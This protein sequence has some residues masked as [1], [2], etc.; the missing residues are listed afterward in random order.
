RPGTME[1][2]VAPIFQTTLGDELYDRVELV[3][4]PEFLREGTAIQDYFN[5][6]KIVVGTY[7][8]QPSE[9]MEQL[10]KGIDA[11]VFHVKYR[12][13]E[14]TKFVD[15][16]WHAAKVAFANEIGRICHQMDI[17][18]QQVHEIFKSDTKLNLSAYY[19]RP[20]GPF[21]GS[22]LPKDVRALQHISTDVGANTHLI[23]TLIRTNEAH[24]LYQFQEATKALAPGARIL[25][26]GV[27]F[28]ADT[29]DLRESPNLDLARRI[30]EA[31]YELDIFDP[32]L[33]ADRLVGQNLGYA[34][35]NLPT[36]NKLLISKEEAES[37]SYDL[38][39]AANASIAQLTL[40]GANI[41]SVGTMA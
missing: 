25:L 34:Y 11:P 2:L 30:L 18:A 35:S 1:Q 15:N 32:S 13:S 22:C 8:G 40:N 21:G 23:D 36:L 17:S 33:I 38:V 10:H 9:R 26:A 20:G 14:I 19:T 31:G 16:T 41:I 6:P 7:D 28:K 12:E 37:R 3:Y 5:P 27:A 29:D 39:V 4:N 24:K